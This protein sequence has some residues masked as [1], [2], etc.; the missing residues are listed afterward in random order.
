MG[1]T[2][3]Y[4]T[5]YSSDKWARFIGNS[6]NNNSMTIIS[7]LGDLTAFAKTAKTDAKESFGYQLTM[8]GFYQPLCKPKFCNFIIIFSIPLLLLYAREKIY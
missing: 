8:W 3:N 2:R 4:R 5:L 6:S 7:A 1:E